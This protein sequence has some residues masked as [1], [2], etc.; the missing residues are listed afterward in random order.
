MNRA[1]IKGKLS[2]MSILGQSQI[3]FGFM[4]DI[5]I[6]ADIDVFGIIGTIFIV[7]S[8]IATVV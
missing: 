2:Q 6:G 4:F 5:L 7:S 3:L 8:L 1:F